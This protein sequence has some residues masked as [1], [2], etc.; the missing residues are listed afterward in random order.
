M[1]TQ[2]KLQALNNFANRLNL[3]AHHRPS[4]DGRMKIDKLFI[5]KGKKTVSPVLEY[6]GIN[7]FLLGWSR[8]MKSADYNISSRNTDS[9]CSNC[10]EAISEADKNYGTPE[11]PTCIHCYHEATV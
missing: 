6:E 4:H 1:N 5:Q 11:L 7:H 3:E 8:S 10:E 2:H 9:I